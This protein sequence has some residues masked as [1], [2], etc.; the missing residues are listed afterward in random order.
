LSDAE[1]EAYFGDRPAQQ[2]KGSYQFII[3]TLDDEKPIGNVMLHDID[4]RPKTRAKGTGFRK[5]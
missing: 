4:P 3:C 2:G 5:D 1:V